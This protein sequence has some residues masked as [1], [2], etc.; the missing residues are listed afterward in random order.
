MPASFL[1]P[2]YTGLAPVPIVQV[3]PPPAPYIS[4]RLEVGGSLVGHGV[5]RSLAS[6]KDREGG[7]EEDVNEEVNV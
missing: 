3:Y 6:P 7:D 4:F 2:T 5:G 1:T